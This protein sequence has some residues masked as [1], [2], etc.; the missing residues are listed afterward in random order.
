[1]NWRIITLIFTLTR[2]LNRIRVK[3]SVGNIGI[4]DTK[5][6]FYANK[7][8][9]NT[10]YS[11]FLEFKSRL[12]HQRDSRKAVSFFVSTSWLKRLK[13]LWFQLKWNHRL[14]LFVVSKPYVFATIPI[15]FRRPRRRLAVREAIS[16]TSE[17]VLVSLSLIN[18]YYF[19]D[20]YL[21]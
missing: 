4:F 16:F 9:K 5:R 1:M 21:I 10:I 20:L 18:K 11:R 19:F 15:Y 8:F 12:A 3:I 17:S 13:P 2:T 14:F 6:A 7:S